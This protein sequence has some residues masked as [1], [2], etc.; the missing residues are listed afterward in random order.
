[1]LGLYPADHL[2]FL[3]F[4]DHQ[5]PLPTKQF[6]HREREREREVN[7]LVVNNYIYLEGERGE[8]C[9]SRY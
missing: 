8:A 9:S 3:D 1:M 2:N 7:W 6:V 4:A 5:T